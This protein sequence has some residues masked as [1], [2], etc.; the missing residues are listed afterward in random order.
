VSQHIIALLQSHIEANDD[1][2]LSVALQY[3][4]KEARQGHSK[5]AQEIRDLVDKARLRQKFRSENSSSVLTS[6][7]V[8]NGL[9]V[10]S[11]S[12][13]RLRDLILAPD[14][15]QRLEHRQRDKLLYYSLQPRNKLLLVGPPGTGKTITAKALAGELHIP[16]NTVILEGLITKFMGETAAKL[17]TLF[18]LINTTPGVYFFDEFDAIGASRTSGNDVGE[19]RRILNTFLQLLENVHARSIVIAATNYPDL[20]DSALSR[21]FDDILNYCLPTPDVALKLLSNG[22]DFLDTSQIEWESLR[23]DLSGMSQAEIVRTAIEVAKGSI[24]GKQ[25]ILTTEDVRSAI[26]ERNKARVGSTL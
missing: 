17:R 15:E 6:E 24:L 14:I 7:A 11:Q 21:R 3:A 25:E 9:L 18:D 5:I 1:Q 19:M 20:L 26:L 22:L 2:F 4:A 16:L 13:V 8:P 10:I 12:E 23:T